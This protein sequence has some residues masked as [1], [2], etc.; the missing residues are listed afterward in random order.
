MCASLVNLLGWLVNPYMPGFS[1]TIYQQLNLPF[2]TNPLA[3]ATP[4]QTESPPGTETT[5]ESKAS[6][7]S[8][9]LLK[10]FA[11][12][13]RPFDGPEAI[14]AGHTIGT[15]TLLV[16]RIDAK[17]VETLRKRFSGQPEE[18]EAGPPFN[19]HLV[20]G[21]IISVEDHPE[22]PANYVLQVQMTPDGKAPPEQEKKAQKKAEN[23]GKD[24]KSRNKA[25]QTTPFVIPI[26]TI[27]AGMKAYYTPADLLNKKVVILCNLQHRNI[28]GIKSQGMMLGAD[29]DADNKR[30]LTVDP[31]TPIG[32]QVL[33]QDHS[34]EFKKVLKLPKELN[35]L[36]MA[37][38][39]NGA[40][41][42]KT[43]PLLAGNTALNVLTEQL[44]Q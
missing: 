35:K 5:G 6:N 40:A 41:T 7:N 19:A 8:S 25:K 32:T 42:S 37:T 9:R 36:V 13:W 27:V 14:A 22:I 2:P 12:T 24:S 1:D 16:A 26:R 34:F 44:Y 15:P 23:K 33:P 3:S 11:F 43:V 18:K 31:A 21:Q 28:K 17:T 4:V 38:D 20:V 29:V 10:Q 30:V 39:E